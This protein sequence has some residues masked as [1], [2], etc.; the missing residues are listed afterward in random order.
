MMKHYKD[1][2]LAKRSELAEK[3]SQRDGIAVERS[4]DALDDVQR[5]AER[6][7]VITVL[8]RNRQLLKD[9]DMAL[10]RMED[11]DYGTCMR[12]E[13]QISPK[14]LN[15]VPWASYCITCQEKVDQ[16]RAQQEKLDFAFSDAA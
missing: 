14:R 11:G 9:I 2:L 12:C 15:A 10:E 8:D 16:E 1:I 13:E 5:S 3:L 4:P 6:E 7:F